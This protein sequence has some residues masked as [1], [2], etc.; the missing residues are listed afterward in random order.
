MDLDTMKHAIV[1]ELKVLKQ[2]LLE[3]D[4]LN[5]MWISETPGQHF[6]PFD[7][8]KGPQRELIRFPR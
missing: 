8:S 7:W 2:L 1:E 5:L 3:E 4:E 6:K